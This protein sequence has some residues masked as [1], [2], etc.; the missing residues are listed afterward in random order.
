MLVIVDMAT[1]HEA[2][3]AVPPQGPVATHTTTTS[4]GS[5][6]LPQPPA[7][8]LQAPAISLQATLSVTTHLGSSSTQDHQHQDISRI[9]ASNPD[10]YYVNDLMDIDE[11]FKKAPAPAP[12]ATKP[13]DKMANINQASFGMVMM[14]KEQVQICKRLKKEV[15]ELR[16]KY[17][18]KDRELKQVKEEFEQHNQELKARARASRAWDKEHARRLKDWDAAQTAYKLADNGACGWEV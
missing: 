15:L 12:M 10:G 4:R 17:E 8:S 14:L 6:V 18:A 3:P 5:A 1:V 11:M 9:W 13:S 2:V 7:C 16:S